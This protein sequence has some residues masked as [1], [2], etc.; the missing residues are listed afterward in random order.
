[1][2]KSFRLLI[3]AAIAMAAT[4]TS[5]AATPRYIFYFI[6]DGMGMNPVMAAAAYN[7]HVLGN[8]ELPLM[9]TFPVAGQIITYSASSD[10]TDSAAAGTALATG[11][12]TKNGMLGMNADTIPV[13][14]VAQKLKNKKG[15]AVG[16]VTNVAP[17][18][19]T[20]G[21]FYAHV[22]NRKMREEIDRQFIASNFDFLAGSALNGL[23][24][25][26]GKDTGILNEYK[27]NG[28]LVTTSPKEAAKSKKRVVLVDQAPFSSGES[29]YC[30]DSIP[31]MNTLCQMTQACLDN[32]YAKNPNGF[33][34]MVEGG[35]IDHALHGNDAGAAVKEIM[36]FN[37]ALKI[38]YDFMQKHPD[39]TLIV[40]TA[41][42][43]TGGLTVGNRA[44]G[45][46]LHI[47]VLEHQKMS[48]SM[49][50]DKCEEMLKSGNIP[51]WDVMK[52]MLT[53]QFG[54]WENVKLSE[55][56]TK[57]LKHSYSKVFEKK[58]SKDEKSLYKSFNNFSSEVFDLINKKA[59]IGFTTGSH[60]G[61][62]VPVYA[63]GV[64]QENFGRVLDN[65]QIQGIMLN[66]AEVE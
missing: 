28:I 11:S 31:T 57:E 2:K 26:D 16:L 9:M 32:V 55:K 20:P 15:Y 10:I 21:A 33:F 49:F 56:D 41:D 19:A 40:V 50:S 35:I 4:L 3:T 18:D 12:K 27:K 24:T 44:N 22:P 6:G 43:D 65:T 52:E 54:F 47:D 51:T 39:E 34:M 14:S 66:L 59:A 30:L 64:G 36:N 46:K 37:D 42:H 5:F 53:K 29:G 23:K 1:M 58:D 8:S 25:E 7:R 48:K 17:D 62:F 13:T 45:Y 38:A 63:V 60:T 61:G